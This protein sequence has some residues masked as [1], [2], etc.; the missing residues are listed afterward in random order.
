M[1][2]HPLDYPVLPTQEICRS[3]GVRPVS[4]IQESLTNGETVLRLTHEETEMQVRTTQ[5]ADFRGLA[6]AMEMHLGALR[7]LLITGYSLTIHELRLLSSG[8]TAHPS[9]SFLSLENNQVGDA[10]GIA[11]LALALSQNQVL[12]T[13]DLSNNL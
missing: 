2:S 10:E 1:A 4:L 11:E 9:I 12:E 5:E 3:Q 7:S 13:L 8:L 6:L